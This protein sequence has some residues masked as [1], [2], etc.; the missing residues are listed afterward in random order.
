MNRQ[1]CQV[2]PP[3]P[4]YA[5]G[6][7]WGGLGL[8]WF[9]RAIALLAL[10]YVIS[11]KLGLRLALFNQYAT[12]VWPPTGIAL[13]ALLLWGNR[14]WPGV[15]TGA[16][17]ANVTTGAGITASGTMAS[18]GIATGNTLEALLGAYLVRHFAGGR[19]PFARAA[20]VF[21]F[22]C[23]AALASTTVSASL[24]VASLWLSGLAKWNDLSAIWATWWIGDAGGDLLFAPILILWVKNWR[25]QWDRTRA[26]EAALLLLVLCVL[27][28]AAFTNILAAGRPID[29][30]LA[31][32]CTPALLWATFRFGQRETAVALLF[33]SGVAIWGWIRGQGNGM[34][35]SA[36]VLLEL[37]AYLGLTSIVILAVGAEISQRKRHEESLDRQA[38][39]LRRQTKLLDLAPVLVRDID[40][41]IQAW[42]SG[43]ERVYGF[44]SSEAIGRVSHILLQTRF[45]QALEQCRS[46]LFANGHWQGEL[47][48]ETRDGR[49]FVVASLWLLYRNKNGQPEA[50]IEVNNDITELR[51]AEDAQLRLAAIVESSDDAIIAKT[52][53]G[54]ILSWNSGAERIYGYTAADAIGRPISI[55]ASPGHHEEMGAIT[56]QLRRGQKMDHFETKRRRKDGTIIDV[57]LTVSPIKSH[58]GEVIAASVVARD[59][60]DR[61]RLEEKLRQAQK[62]ESIGVLA[63]GVAHD[64][65]NLLVGILGNASLALEIIPPTDPA[66]PLLQ[67]VLLAGQR[68]ADLTRQLLAYSGRG[69]FVIQPLSLSELVSEISGLI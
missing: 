20:D 52:L 57:A 23:L 1:G 64:F 26:L 16:I 6:V 34:L 11:A 39:I 40:D 7:S 47:E 56:E 66:H 28:I 35:S 61:K 14:L 49:R 59:I 32:L 36:Y 4:W 29:L 55:L 5:L 13:A 21:R 15:L 12:A 24:G 17:I 60:T 2:L 3:M 46:T 44:S 54:T 45:S 51:R 43:A 31:F 30:G 8:T 68:A 48:H 53:D 33:I 19:H 63:G 10:T 27:A 38:E 25:M 9:M 50:I 18:I 62:L 58:T 37:Q 22:A 41:R 42:N 65:N 69:R 67:D